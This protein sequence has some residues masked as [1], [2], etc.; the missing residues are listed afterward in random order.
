MRDVAGWTISRHA[1]TRM[2]ERRITP[3]QVV[4]LLRHRDEAVHELVAE[5]RVLVSGD[6]IAIIVNPQIK[7]VVTVLLAGEDKTTWYDAVEGRNPE[8][9][10]LSLDALIAI[11]DEVAPQKNPWTKKP[12]RTPKA[13]PVTVT[14]VFDRFP[15]L[16]ETAREVLKAHGFPPDDLRRVKI[17]ESGKIEIDLTSP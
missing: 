17:L 10:Q 15:S 14:N 2:E 7:V 16:V 12:P 4:T 3:S 9:Y 5:Q 1:R 6:D 8:D 11:A 13:G